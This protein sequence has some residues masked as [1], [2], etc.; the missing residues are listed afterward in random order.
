MA[1]S[2]IRL[3]SEA[4]IQ[5]FVE[6]EKI[7]QRNLHFTD[8]LIFKRKKL[9]V[10]VV[11]LDA[12][13]AGNT[14]SADRE[15]YLIEESTMSAVKVQYLMVVSTMSAVRVL[16]PVASRTLSAVVMLHPIAANTLTAVT[17]FATTAEVLCRPS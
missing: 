14:L 2:R 10:M 11:N 5:D 1:I 12:I 15:L 8:D 17:M 13:I 6:M 7:C 9:I 4:K 3:Q 16:H